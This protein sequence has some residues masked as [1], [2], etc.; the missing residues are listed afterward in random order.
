VV[1][2]PITAFFTPV[3]SARTAISGGINAS[4]TG[5]GEV[6][7]LV[8]IILAPFR[9]IGVFYKCWQIRLSIL[10]GDANVVKALSINDGEASAGREI[11][12][13]F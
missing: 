9:K 5:T 6:E 11:N 3:F 12:F 7:D 1:R 4:K 8:F 2:Q 13:N 10:L